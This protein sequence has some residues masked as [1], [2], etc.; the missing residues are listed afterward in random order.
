MFNEMTNQQLMSVDGGSWLADGAK[1]KLLE[2][3]VTC[4]FKYYSNMSYTGTCTRG[5]V[6]YTVR[7]NE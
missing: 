4:A 3:A 1:F 7:Y 5:G 2:I 6:K